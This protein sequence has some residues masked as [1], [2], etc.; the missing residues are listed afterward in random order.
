MSPSFVSKI[1]TKGSFKATKPSQHQKG[2]LF[3][4]CSR[5]TCCVCKDPKLSDFEKAV[6]HVAASIT[7]GRVATYGTIAQVIKPTEGARAARAVGTA[8]RK[9]PYWKEG[10]QPLVPCHRV[11][12][13]DYTLGGYMGVKDPSSAQL[14]RKRALMQKEGVPIARDR[15]GR[16][17]VGSPDP[18]SGQGSTHS[19]LLSVKELRSLAEAFVDT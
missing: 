2:V 8:L 17:I 5:Q 12:A 4:K 10:C 7:P 19:P 16:W 3:S 14:T 6:Y 15:R 13:A 11:V 18:L 9:N 1:A